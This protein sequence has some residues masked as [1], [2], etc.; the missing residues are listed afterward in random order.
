MK[1]VGFTAV[2][3]QR[4]V[5]ANYDYASGGMFVACPFSLHGLFLG[6][7]CKPCNN[8]SWIFPP[9]GKTC[10]TESKQ[11][12]C[13]GM[14][15]LKLASKPYLFQASYGGKFTLHIPRQVPVPMVLHNTLAESKKNARLVC[16]VFF[17]FF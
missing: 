17:F 12:K 15:L 4:L 7:A 3:G 5:V 14:M 16:M 13:T 10:K 11:L 1:G 9:V 6:H 8:K 2:S